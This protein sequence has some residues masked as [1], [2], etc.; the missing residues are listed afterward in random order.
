[1]AS[2]G[3][4]AAAYGLLL[5][6]S[7]GDVDA[8]TRINVILYEGPAPAVTSDEVIEAAY[9]AD[10][11]RASKRPSKEATAG[12]ERDGESAGIEQESREGES[13]REVVEPKRSRR[14]KTAERSPARPNA[15]AARPPRKP[16]PTRSAAPSDEGRTGRLARR[17]SRLPP[18]PDEDPSGSAL[19]AKAAA[20]PPELGG[21]LAAIPAELAEHPPVLVSLI[22]P[23]YP[24]RARDLGVEG[25]V[26]LEVVIDRAGRIEQPVRVVR[27][28]PGLDEVALESV[29]HWRFRPAADRDGRPLRVIVEIPFRFELR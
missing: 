27:S 15:V 28:T 23:K 4:H 14:P 10:P 1:M 7:S 6:A 12:R 3:I 19:Q 13:T 2:T 8:P 5:Y 29:R 9:E 21:H 11:A 25:R 20:L 26:V 18:T 24:A 17:S 22:K 16:E